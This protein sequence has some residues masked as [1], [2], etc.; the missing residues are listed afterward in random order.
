[1]TIITM[2]D[3][4]NPRMEKARTIPNDEQVLRTGVAGGP[5]HVCDWRKRT[6]KEVYVE[7]RD[8]NVN[9]QV[10]HLI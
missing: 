10:V 8:E 2:I 7:K 9:G 3:P 1:M 6:R 4:P 5:W